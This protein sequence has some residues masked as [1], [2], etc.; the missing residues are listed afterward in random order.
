MSGPR[1]AVVQTPTRGHVVG[2]FCSESP[3]ERGT[4]PAGMMLGVE[5]T[6]GKYFS[7]GSTFG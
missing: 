5:N 3:W 4:V 1:D 2:A 7:V 6:T